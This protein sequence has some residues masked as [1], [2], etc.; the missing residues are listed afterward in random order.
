MAG[1]MLAAIGVGTAIAT[2]ALCARYRSDTRKAAKA[3]KEAAEADHRKRFAIP[4]R[5][6]M[7]TFRMWDPHWQKYHTVSVVFAMPLHKIEEELDHRE[8]KRRSR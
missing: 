2:I 4:R 6:P 7:R 1:T 8:M 5:R 3:A